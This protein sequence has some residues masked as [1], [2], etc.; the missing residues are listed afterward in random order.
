M[1][2]TA[3]KIKIIGKILFVLL[4]NKIPITLIIGQK[5]VDNNVVSYRKYGS[6][7]TITLSFEEF[8]KY[9]KNISIY[10]KNMRIDNGP[11]R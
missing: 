4:I 1:L 9:I 2:L 6:E 7:E 11:E 8:C 3:N 5:E 10:E